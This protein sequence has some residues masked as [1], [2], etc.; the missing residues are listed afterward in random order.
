MAYR[1]TEKTRRHRE[2]R[3]DGILQAALAL[4]ARVGF[5]G[6]SVA[7]IA[8]EAGVATGSVYRYFPNKAE[9]SSEVFRRASARELARVGA[10]LQGPGTATER[11]ERAARQFAQRALKGHRLA[12]ALIAEPVDPL[13]DADRLEFRRRYA[14]LFAA[15]IREGMQEG[16]FVSQNS[17]LSGAAMVGALAEALIGP[18]ANPIAEQ[19]DAVT[20]QA[21]IDQLAAFC[22]R[23]AGASG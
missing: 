6:A 19:G 20:Q 23:A 11:L 13:V 12:Y 4:T 17:A 1:E 7:A 14:D 16:T 8:R 18:L 21:W 10:D 3:H 15:V 9:L 2:Q 22:L 5:A